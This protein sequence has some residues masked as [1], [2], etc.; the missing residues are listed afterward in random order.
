MVDISSGERNYHVFYQLL[1]N[2]DVVRLCAPAAKSLACLSA[3]GVTI[4][5]GANDAKDFVAV[6]AALETLA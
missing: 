2:D 1:T 5:D 4:V 6:E 3:D